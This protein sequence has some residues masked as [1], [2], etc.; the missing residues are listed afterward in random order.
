VDRQNCSVGKR[1][2]R[3]G[4]DDIEE[5][6]RGNRRETL[7]VDDGLDQL[8]LRPRDLREAEDQRQRQLP[9]AEVG[10]DRL[11]QVPDPREYPLLP[12]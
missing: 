8:P 3:T 11:A 5:L 9:L 7:V 10:E 2:N 6:L 1:R 12:G 4:V